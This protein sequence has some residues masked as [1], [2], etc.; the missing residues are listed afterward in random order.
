M[1]LENDKILKELY[2]EE[3]SKIP[4]AFRFSRK[5]FIGSLAVMGV[6][7]VS[8]V[9]FIILFYN[10][11][12][13]EVIDTAPGSQFQMG[14]NIYDNRFAE[15]VVISAVV[16]GLVSFWVLVSKWFE[17]SA[18]KKA[19]N[20]AQMIHIAEENRNHLKWMNWKAENRLDF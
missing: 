10:S 5:R 16:L 2:D 8:I 18:F 7:L 6:L 17:Q 11:G 3:I 19:S 15:A 12:S 1:R 13:Y 20:L 9:V 14:V 4:F